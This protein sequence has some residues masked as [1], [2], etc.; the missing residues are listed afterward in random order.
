LIEKLDIP[1]KCNQFAFQINHPGLQTSLQPPASGLIGH[2]LDENAPDEI[3][4]KNLQS[5][6]H[7]IELDREKISLIGELINR[8]NSMDENGRINR[9]AVVDSF[10]NNEF[11]R[12]QKAAKKKPDHKLGDAANRLIQKILIAC[13]D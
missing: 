9:I 7:G 12:A 5:L 13:N 11:N 1:N 3:P 8:K 10:T 6:T 4:P 2:T